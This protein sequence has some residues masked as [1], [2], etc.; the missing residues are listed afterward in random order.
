MGKLEQRSGEL[1]SWLRAGSPPG[2]A[3][4]RLPPE[5]VDP[6]PLAEP[7][8]ARAHYFKVRVHEMCL[9]HRRRW[10]ATYDPLV[11]TATG[12]RYSGEPRTLP[13]TIGP[14]LIKQNLSEV[15][16][17]FRFT[18]TTVAGPHPY[19]GGVLDLTIVLYR[20]RGDQVA[21]RL[22]SLVD[23]CS[24]L[25][26]FGTSFDAYSKVANVVLD[27]LD[28]VLGLQETVPMLGHRIE[29]DPVDEFRAGHYVLALSGELDPGELWVR[30]NRLE[31]GRTPDTAS[32]V[33][34]A[35]YVL[36]SL[37]RED[38]R[39][40]AEELP[41]FRPLWQRVV[42]EAGVPREDAWRT[43]KAH[44][45][46]LGEALELSP[47]LTRGQARRL[48]DELITDMKTVH[49]RA[50]SLAELGPAG[51]AVDEVRRDFAEILDL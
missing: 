40:D 17:G 16:G 46:V 34:D 28:Q 23:S 1:L 36:Y 8:Q 6:P 50:L 9:S 11:L 2:S 4:L 37:A 21:R 22:L 3:C 32:P 10:F 33:D 26:D 20:L 39:N 38:D 44:M 24:R 5:R 14:S 45:A 12:F 48:R 43:A 49:D 7:F 13:F 51:A 35:D 29:F 42:R 15:P 27:G 41:W 31:R 30:H 25:I 47:D 19:Q 18:D